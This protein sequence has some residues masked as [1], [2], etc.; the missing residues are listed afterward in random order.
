MAPTLDF[1]PPCVNL[2]RPNTLE[3]M[4]E[5]FQPHSSMEKDIASILEK[6]GIQTSESIVKLEGD[7][8]LK[9]HFQKSCS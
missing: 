9:V 6:A 5:D 8:A 7:T 3:A 4:I 1:A 2:K